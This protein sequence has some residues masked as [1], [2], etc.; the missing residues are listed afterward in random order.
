MRLYLYSLVLL[1]ADAGLALGC[2]AWSHSFDWA[3]LPRA[4]RTELLTG[5]QTGAD[6]LLLLL[7]R[8]VANALAPLAFPR[9]AAEAHEYASAAQ[10][11]TQ[12]WPDAWRLMRREACGWLVWALLSSASAYS[13]LS[14]GEAVGQVARGTALPRS[15]WLMLAQAAA[16]CACSLAFAARCHASAR[17][18]RRG[19][20]SFT[21]VERAEG[22]L[23]EPLLAASQDEGEAEP[24]TARKGTLR[25]L[26]LLSTPDGVKVLLAFLCLVVAVVCDVAIPNFKADAL[27]AILEH[28]HARLRGSTP[29]QALSSSFH[30]AVIS[31]AVASLGAGLFAGARGGLLSV[32]N[33][34]LV[35]RL[36]QALFCKLLC[37]DLCALD[38]TATGKLLSRLTTDTAQVG[39]VL[40]LNLNVASRSLLRLLLTTAYLATLSVPLTLLALASSLLFFSITFFFSRYQRVSSKAAQEATA[41]S[42]AVAEQSLSLLRTVRAFAAEAWEERR[43]GAVLSQRLGVLERQAQAYSA[44]TVA[45]S[46]LDNAQ[47]VLLLLAGGQMYAA[48]RVSGAV[49]SKFVFYSGVLSA[50]IQNCADMIGDTFRALGASDEVFRLLDEPAPAQSADDAGLPPCADACCVPGGEQVAARVELQAVTFAY[51]SRP[52]VRVL[53]GISLHI[54]PGRQVALV[55]LSGSGKSTTIQ[56]LLRFYDPD[57][58]RILFN[59]HDI[60]KVSTRW[61]RSMISVVGQEPPLF[62]VSIR[63]NIAF[64]S[65]AFSDAQVEQAAALACATTFIEAMPEGYQTMVGPKGVALSGSQKQRIAI[66]RAIIRRPPLLLLDEAT[67]A[68]DASSE[69][70]VQDALERASAGRSVLVVAHRLS[71][72]RACDTIVVMRSGAIVESGT[73]EALLAARGAYHE[74]VVRQLAEA[75]PAP[76]EQTA[77]PSSEEEDTLAVPAAE[78]GPARFRESL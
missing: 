74:L 35:V 16:A 76:T 65:D 42:N 68:L 69:R 58:G 67:S 11:L 3:S 50:S 10:E 14:L 53:N 21:A 52:Q 41:E 23:N 66:A 13:L 54:D 5:A 46:C 34:R 33:A 17:S 22:G 78:D 32:C 1:T 63:D 12:L 49:L 70:D 37:K 4:W 62:S 51:P 77:T 7:A 71:T 59:G 6:L 2:Y 40:G 18:A 25:R 29:E 48:G 44:Y 9:R 45:F 19:R 56:L 31:L 28:Q 72:V 43:F 60:A 47:S 64:A 55:G 36:Q 57:S 24:G 75:P 26:V 20:V 8:S 39:D 38:A 73:H 30:R 27:N 15:W 61:L